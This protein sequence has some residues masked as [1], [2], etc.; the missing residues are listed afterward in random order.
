MNKTTFKEQHESTVSRI[1]G[2]LGNIIEHQDRA[3]F[4]F[5]APFIAGYFFPS[6]DP[7]TAII[8]IYG[9]IV[10]SLF[11]RPLGAIFFGWYGDKN[12]RRSGLLLSLYGMSISTMA[13][14]FL[15]SY[16]EWG[17]YSPCLLFLIRCMQNFFGSGEVITGGIYVMEH[18]Q[19]AKR[20]IFSGFFEASTMLGVLL[21]S[22]Q[23]AFFAY[24]GI[25]ES[26]WKLLFIIPGVIGF[27]IYLLRH[28]SAESP[29]FCKEAYDRFSWKA[30]WRERTAVFAVA[31]TNGFTYGTYL[32]SIRFM[33]TYLKATT[34]LD[35]LELTSINTLLSV[36]D[37]LILPLFGFAAFYLSPAFVMGFATFATAVL[38]LPLFL[39]MASAKTISVILAVRLTI[40]V[41][42]VI[43]AAPFRAWIQGL[44]G[45]KDRC[46]VLNVGASFGQLA[47]EAPLTML[48]LIFVRQGNEWIP[49]LFLSLLGLATFATILSFE[50]KKE[51]MPQR[52]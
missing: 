39:W 16:A 51:L 13:I 28:Y 40:V 2:L 18:T 6:D 3:L 29:E 20:S 25:L 1:S 33:N 47:I 14:G 11:M 12:G 10:L 41:L 42:G 24:F 36:I 5:I 30:V 44:V 17:Y 15:P 32:L 49:G 4:A 19:E 37:T 48:S 7:L 9:V 52:E 43:F 21:A 35:S 34:S 8:D 31:M 26:H 45:A 27:M 22:A 38:A 23:T 50:T 46:T